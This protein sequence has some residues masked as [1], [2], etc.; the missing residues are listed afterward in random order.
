[1]RAIGKFI[2]VVAAVFAIPA[3]AQT[4]QNYIYDVHGRLVA[5]SNG[6]TNT[7]SA[8]TYLLDSADNRTNRGRVLTSA[9]STGQN[10]LSSGEVLVPGQQLQSPDNRFV[11]VLQAGDGNAVLY[12]L[13]NIAL[14]ST[15]TAGGSSL[16]LT[17]ESGGNVVLKNY[18]G[19]TLFQTGTGGNPGAVLVLQSDGNLVVYTSSG[20]PIWSS[21]T[22]GH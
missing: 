17:M 22:G 7:G 3:A 20:T 1:M 8:T 11:L 15:S 6:Q 10:R 4:T 9:R 19:A 16:T 13:G 18:L 12:W 5:L 14:W 21:G 2:G